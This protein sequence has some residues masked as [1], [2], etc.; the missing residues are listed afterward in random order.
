MNHTCIKSHCIPRLCGPTG[1]SLSAFRRLHLPRRS[2]AH[3]ATQSAPFL[4][5]RGLPRARSR[6]PPIFS[7][8]AWRLLARPSSL[9]S[10]CTTAW[11][12]CRR[13][14][15]VQRRP[16][17]A[18]HS[19]DMSHAPQARSAPSTTVAA[20][21]TVGLHKADTILNRTPGSPSDPDLLRVQART[22]ARQLHHR[23]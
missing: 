23:R 6:R 22:G 17:R 7:P 10:P 11:S 15:P 16:R 13:A 21:I 1:G 14:C 4:S 2:S 3:R 19:A 9:A 8:A 5:S 18:G 20:I 12:A